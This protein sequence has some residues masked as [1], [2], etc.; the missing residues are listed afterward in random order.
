[1]LNH[2]VTFVSH[3]FNFKGNTKT[4]SNFF[5]FLYYQNEIRTLIII[6]LGSK[7]DI[8]DYNEQQQQLIN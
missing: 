8:D 7:L 5:F 1:M 4:S 2:S 6:D 3:S